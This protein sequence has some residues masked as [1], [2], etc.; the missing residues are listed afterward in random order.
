M[1][2]AP[3]G[4]LALLWMLSGLAFAVFV[5]AADIVAAIQNSPSSNAWLKANAQAVANL[6]INVESG[7]NTTAYNGTCCYGVLQMNERN[8]ERYTKLTP[9]QYQQI[10]LQDQ[11]N[12][13]SSLTVD[14][15]KA[16]SVQQLIGMGSFDGRPVDGNLVLA[17]V[18]LGIGNCQKMINS[19]SCKGFADSNGTT[20]CSMAD[21]MAGANNN[22]GSTA[23]PPSSG[24]NSGSSGG[25]NSS[26]GKFTPT[27]SCVKD[28]SGRCLPITAAL[29]AGFAEGAG[30]PMPKVKQHLQLIF[31][32]VVTL[33]IAACLVTL[34][35]SYGNGKI[36]LA[37][38]KLHVIRAGITLSIVLGVMK[39]L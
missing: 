36:P 16:G 2:T 34:W 13:W 22:G 21:K 32:S 10:S 5:G 19:G 12:A 8:I 37:E 38:L 23:N 6:A 11:I 7:G 3:K 26:F 15:M 31:A 24:G 1:K 29:M 33:I 4:M 28:G 27:E 20:I 25:T 9:E 14:A 17:C 39:A 18:Q 35:S 30:V